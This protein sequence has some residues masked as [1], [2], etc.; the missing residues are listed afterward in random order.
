MRRPTRAGNFS[1]RGP[2][3]T[4]STP[5]DDLDAHPIAWVPR[6]KALMPAKPFFVYWAPGATHA[7]HHVPKEWSDKYKGKFDAGCDV[8]REQ[9]LARQKELGV[10]RKDANLTQR[11]D[12]D[13]AR[14]DI[15]AELKPRLTSEMELY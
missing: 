6:Q 14:D 1:R 12:E 3:L 2:R 10:V 5:P 15:A 4:S 13:P 7:P 11:H 9:I 8:M